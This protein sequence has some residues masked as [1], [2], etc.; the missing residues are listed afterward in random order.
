LPELLAKLAPRRVL[1]AGAVDGRGNAL[2]D[3]AVRRAC[4]SA[5]TAGNLD[6]SGEAAWSVA[7]LTA[8]ALGA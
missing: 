4:V 3:E 6:V 1:L 8:W 2:S 5:A 7:R